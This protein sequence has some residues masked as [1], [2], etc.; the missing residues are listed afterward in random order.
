M[1]NEL[2]TW[3]VVT[4]PYFPPERGPEYVAPRCGCITSGAGAPDNADG[5]DNDFYVDTDTGAIYQKQDGVWTSIGSGAT[6]GGGL[7]GTGSPEGSVT[8]D[9]GQTYLDTTANSLWIKKTGTGNTGWI[10]LI[11]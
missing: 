1:A 9:P 3:G 6:G 5:G 4:D 10:Q 7:A 8:A 2:G 11:A